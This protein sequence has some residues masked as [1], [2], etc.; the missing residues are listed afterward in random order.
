MPGL[1]WVNRLPSRR[2]DALHTA[3]KALNSTGLR[4]VERKR[5]EIIG[6]AAAVGVTLGNGGQIQGNGHANGDAKIAAMTNA[7]KAFFGEEE[8]GKSKDLLYLMMKAS[9]CA[10]AW[11]S[12]TFL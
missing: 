12:D 7:E 3:K 4:I 5:K 2:R 9:E 1:A 6:E 10:G 11:R 8:Q